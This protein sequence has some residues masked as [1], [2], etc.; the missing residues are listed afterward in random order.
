MTRKLCYI[1]KR[2]CTVAR[3]SFCDDCRKAQVENKDEIRRA[4][5][6]AQITRAHTPSRKDK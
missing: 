6:P 2:I 4:V 1:D 3:F 5:T